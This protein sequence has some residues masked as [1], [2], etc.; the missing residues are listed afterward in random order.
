MLAREQARNH[1]FTVA[2][3]VRDRAGKKEYSRRY[4]AEYTADDKHAR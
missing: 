4:A 2:P 1:M 3:R